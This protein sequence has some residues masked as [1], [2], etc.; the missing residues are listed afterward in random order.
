MQWPRDE[1][2]NL[3]RDTRTLWYIWL[4]LEAVDLMVVQEVM[5][6][7]VLDLLLTTATIM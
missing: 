6:L 4:V 5:N 2:I 1:D 3:V 7:Q